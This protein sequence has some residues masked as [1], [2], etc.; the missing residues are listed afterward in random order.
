MRDERK[1]KE[2]AKPVFNQFFIVTKLFTI[3]LSK[4]VFINIKLIFN[5]IF[6]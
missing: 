5:D 1:E 6:S 4:S 3:N 2:A